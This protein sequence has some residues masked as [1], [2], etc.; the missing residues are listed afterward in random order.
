VASKDGIFVAAFFGGRIATGLVALSAGLFL[1]ADRRL[2]VTSRQVWRFPVWEILNV[3]F[4][5]M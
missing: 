3:N 4:V 5:D 2:R 1:L